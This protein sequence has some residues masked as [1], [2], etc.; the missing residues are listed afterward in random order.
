[1]FGE[2][3]ANNLGSKTNFFIKCD[4]Y[5]IGNSQA[6][7]FGKCLIYF[8]LILLKCLRVVEIQNTLER[9]LTSTFVLVSNIFL[10]FHQNNLKI[11][12]MARVQ[13]NDVIINER[14]SSFG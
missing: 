14:T 3:H 1:M 2:A 11:N 7:L 12:N 13:I 8:G 4:Y 6:T 10:H 9:N 5:V